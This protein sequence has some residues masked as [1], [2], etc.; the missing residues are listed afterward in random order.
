MCLFQRLQT[1]A[2]LG[3]DT[4][5]NGISCSR[6]RSSKYEFCVFELRFVQLI[7]FRTD[8]EERQVTLDKEVNHI[9]I[10]RS[11]LMAHI[12]NLDDERHVALCSKISLPSASPSAAFRSGKPWRSRSPAGPPK[13]HSG[14]RKKLI[15]A[16]LPGVA[17]T[18]ASAL[19]LTS[20]LISEDLPTLDLPEKTISGKSDFGELIRTAGG[21][22]QILLIL[23]VHGVPPYCR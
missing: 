1:E 22:L 19:R 16:V 14:R 15:V 12:E 5:C 21:K 9:E 4:G 18:R 8:D 23:K 3:G 10:V 20:L 6:N 13:R 17:L 11:R 7:A 2:G